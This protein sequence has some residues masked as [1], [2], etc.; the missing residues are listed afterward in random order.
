MLSKRRPITHHHHPLSAKTSPTALV[1]PYFMTMQSASAPFA[2]GHKS[3]YGGR[4]AGN[5]TAYF[6]FLLRGRKPIPTWRRCCRGQYH[7]GC[8]KVRAAL[9]PPP[10]QQRS[11]EPS[12]L[13]SLGERF[14][15]KILTNYN[16]LSHLLGNF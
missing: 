16:C 3:K 15:A 2:V 6:F 9:P 8:P 4:Q 7:Y 5:Q 10:C 11:N 1:N 14:S 12:P 13:A